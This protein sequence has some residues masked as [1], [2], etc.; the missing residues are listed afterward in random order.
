MS[1]QIA[2]GTWVEIHNIVLRPDERSAHIPE[3]TRQIPLEMRVKGF[4]LEPARI[5]DGVKVETL[6]GRHVKGRLVEVNPPYRHSFGE[7]IAELSG[8]GREVRTLLFGTRSR[9]EA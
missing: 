7:P 5:G 4:L 1:E 3:D 2:K 9:H 6:T 8:I